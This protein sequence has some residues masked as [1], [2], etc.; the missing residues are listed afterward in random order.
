M[1][2]HIVSNLKQKKQHELVFQ[3]FAMTSNMGVSIEFA[4]HKSQTQL[5]FLTCNNY[6]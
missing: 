1:H 5:I 6:L 3:V 2:V 4:A